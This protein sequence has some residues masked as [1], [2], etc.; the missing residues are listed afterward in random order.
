[1]KRFFSVGHVT[2]DILADE[3]QLGG[4][5]LYAALCAKN[6]G[7]ESTMLTSVDEETAELLSKVGVESLVQLGLSTTTFRHHYELGGKRTSL[8][9]SQGD[10]LSLADI[11]SWKLEGNDI[12]MVCP[13]MHEIGIQDIATYI[14]IPFA[15]LP[16]GWF[17][18]VEPDQ[19]VVHG[20]NRGKRLKLEV[21]LVVVSE[22]DVSGDEQ[23]WSWC[24]ERS[25][26]AVMTRGENS[27]L[28]FHEGREHEIP[29]PVYVTDANPTGAGDVFSTAM[30]VAMKEGVHPKDAASLG[31]AA[32]AFKV[33][34]K[35]RFEFPTRTDI[36]ANMKHVS[37]D[38][39]VDQGA[40]VRFLKGQ[41]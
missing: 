9:L 11:Q 7:Y 8:C 25:V 40:V 19:T 1:M 5:S 35:T 36:F 26:V 21:S 23:G 14:Q 39:F 37:G 20:A 6:L 3:T 15:L 41:P 38:Y 32:A 27:I 16:Q 17:R 31:C 30:Y 13:N 22:E 33:K 24:K 29:L 18:K 28:L 2:K 10:S 12:L 34:T 4:S